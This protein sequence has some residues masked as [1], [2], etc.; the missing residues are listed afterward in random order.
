MGC[1]YSTQILVIF[2]DNHVD[3]TKLDQLTRN[4]E[5][6]FAEMRARLTE[7]MTTNSEAFAKVTE[8]ISK[9]A[10]E[11][12][13]GFSTVMNELGYMAEINSEQFQALGFTVKFEAIRA[14]CVEK[15]SA[16]QVGLDALHDLGAVN[17]KMD[18]GK[19]LL[20][21][22]TPDVRDKVTNLAI[23]PQNLASY[24]AFFIDGLNG[25]SVGN[26]LA[27]DILDVVYQMTKGNRKVIK[28]ISDNLTGILESSIFLQTVI[29]YINYGKVTSEK[30]AKRYEKGMKEVYD[31]RRKMEQECED[32]VEDLLEGDLEYELK[33]A[34][35]SVQ[36]AS[37]KMEKILND[38]YDWLYWYLEI[39]AGDYCP[40]ADGTFIEKRN[41]NGLTGVLWYIP[42]EKVLRYAQNKKQLNELDRLTN[43]AVPDNDNNRRIDKLVTGL[44]RANI[45]YWGLSVVD[46]GHNAYIILDNSPLGKSI[47]NLPAENALYKPS[48]SLKFALLGGNGLYAKLMLR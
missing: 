36:T 46:A 18:D 45:E 16:I 2:R 14:S 47:Q 28:T 35:K 11:N 40:Y 48:T 34:N 7:L 10:A 39:W 19:W 24:I 44:K 13:R 32:K 26:G 17:G 21:F 30:T 6:W 23:G 33:T 25:D 9:G 43:E 41:I 5:Y 42:K 12:A 27:F 29:D 22:S 37:S 15:I 31:N 3:T 8:S 1:Y 20:I 4:T 38:K